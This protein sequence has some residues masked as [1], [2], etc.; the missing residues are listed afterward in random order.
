[1]REVMP[2]RFQALIATMAKFSSEISVS[3]K[4]SDTLRYN[5]SLTPSGVICVSASVNASA[6]FSR[7]LNSGDSR[8]TVR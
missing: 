6:A 3:E 4:C 5:S 7:A 1:M 8:Q 2:K